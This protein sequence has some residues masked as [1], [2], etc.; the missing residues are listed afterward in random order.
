[1]A[2]VSKYDDDDVVNS[3]TLYDI[4]PNYMEAESLERLCSADSKENGPPSGNSKE[5]VSRAG[6]KE[7]PVPARIVSTVSSVARARN[8]KSLEG[9]NLRI[10]K[11]TNEE[12][13]MLGL[14]GSTKT[15]LMISK[16][17]VDWVGTHFMY[18]SQQLTTTKSFIPVMCPT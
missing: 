8:L 9:L 17:T 11:D 6:S 12:N 15:M 2:K 13:V 5:G 14:S 1:M 18:T 4:Y 7:P 10:V 16:Y 3:K